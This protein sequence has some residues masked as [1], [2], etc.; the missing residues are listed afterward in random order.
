MARLDKLI[1]LSKLPTYAPEQTTYNGYKL[2]VYKV[3]HRSLAPEIFVDNSLV[4]K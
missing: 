2:H 3:S 4:N 1:D